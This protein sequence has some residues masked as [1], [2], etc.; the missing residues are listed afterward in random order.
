MVPTRIV[1]AGVTVVLGACRAPSAHA[2][3][4]EDRSPVVAEGKLVTFT[5]TTTDGRFD[6]EQGRFGIPVVIHGRA[7]LLLV[8]HGSNRTLLTDAGA[9]SARVRHFFAGATKTTTHEKRPGIKFVLDSTADV[10]VT[11]G[12]VVK[13]YWGEFEPVVLDSLRIAASL[14]L[15]IAL[16]T[17]ID[18]SYW[19]P[20]LGILGRDLLTEFDLEFNVRARVVRLYERPGTSAL[21]RG[22]R[23]ED[24]APARVVF[25]EQPDTAS[26]DETDR[27]QVLSRW[28]RRI[29]QTSDM[30]LPLTI[31]GKA[32]AGMFDSGAYETMMNWTAARALGLDRSSP[33]VRAVPTTEDTTY[34][35]SGLG[36]RLGGRPLRTVPV[37]ITDEFFSAYPDFETKPL[38]LIG[39]SSVE[40]RALLLA[41]SAGLAC[42]R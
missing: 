21:P 42:V 17:E 8:D 35:A 11:S 41:Y 23:R 38:V 6:I 16:T 37:K 13:Q 4:P 28:G 36:I 39:L 18:G 24:C 33:G 30:E 32:F 7:I 20:F 29:W 15:D 1:L 5:A 22:W 40:D 3:S 19:R 12:F 27:Q 9:D 26:M 10:T 14:H 2:P 34:V 25:G 31:Q